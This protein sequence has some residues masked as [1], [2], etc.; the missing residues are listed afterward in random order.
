MDAT[1]LSRIVDTLVS[2][3]GFEEVVA[4]VASAGI[5]QAERLS[6]MAKEQEAQEIL[7]IVE[8]MT[9]LILEDEEVTN[10]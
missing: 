7:L 6:A 3:S 1:E 9:A 10:G 5:N 8:G 4:A 2:K